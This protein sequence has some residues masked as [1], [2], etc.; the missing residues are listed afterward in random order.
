MT[1]HNAN[2]RQ[3]LDDF[4]SGAGCTM[5]GLVALKIHD[6]IRKCFIQNIAKIRDEVE[7]AEPPF[8]VMTLR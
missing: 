8:L 7:R 1:Q 4:G 2:E 3:K 5:A 6:I